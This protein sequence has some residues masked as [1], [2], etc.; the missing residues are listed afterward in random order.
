ME[1]HHSKFTLCIRNSRRKRKRGN[2]GNAAAMSQPKGVNSMS[3]VV[4]KN[5]VGQVYRKPGKSMYF[6]LSRT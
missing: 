1:K 3:T 2:K 4:T 5:Q 6:L